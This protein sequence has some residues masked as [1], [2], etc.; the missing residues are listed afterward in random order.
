MDHLRWQGPRFCDGACPVVD[1]EVDSRIIR[2]SRQISN[3]GGIPASFESPKVRLQPVPVNSGDTF[4]FRAI[5]R[6]FATGQRRKTASGI[7]ARQTQ[8][9]R[10]IRF[11]Q[12]GRG[13]AI[14]DHSVVWD[15]IGQGLRPLRHAVSWR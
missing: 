11:V 8:P 12:Y 7:E 4:E 5:G 14:T 3:S 13:F 10:S 6:P 15:T 2:T 1:S 9:R